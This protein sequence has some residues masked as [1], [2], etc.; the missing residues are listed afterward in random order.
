MASTSAKMPGFSTARTVP[1][2]D[3]TL[4]HSHINFCDMVRIALFLV[5]PVYARIYLFSSILVVF[6]H[7]Y[8]IGC[9]GVCIIHFSGGV[10]RLNS[11]W[12]VIYG[13]LMSSFP[14]WS[15]SILRIFWVGPKIDGWRWE[16]VYWTF[17]ARGLTYLLPEY[18]GSDVKVR[19]Y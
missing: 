4:L 6:G 18:Y 16:V 7:V 15:T 8:V 17:V 2:P 9:T 3:T 12:D 19:N 13:L 1:V 11:V 14:S 10:F 5:I